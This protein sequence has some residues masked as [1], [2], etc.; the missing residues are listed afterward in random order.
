MYTTHLEE[1]CEAGERRGAGLADGAG[2]AAGEEVKRRP[3]LRLRLGLLLLL[4]GLPPRGHGGG[5]VDGCG[6]HPHPRL[7]LHPYPRRPPLV[8]SPPRP[9]ER[10][11]ECD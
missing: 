6:G 10:G 7:R 2:D 8:T 3:E 11:L 1:D 4:R 9:L 5:T